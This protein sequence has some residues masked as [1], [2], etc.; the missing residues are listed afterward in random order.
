MRGL[1]ATGLLVLM[2]VAAGA[3]PPVQTAAVA[4]KQ[5]EPE[6]VTLPDGRVLGVIDG[7]S[8]AVDG[9]EWRLLG[10]DAPEI[11]TARCEGERRIG[12]IAMRRLRALIVSGHAAGLALTLVHSGRSDRHK[13][14]LGTLT[15]GGVDVRDT[16]IAELLARPYNG[17]VKKGWCSRDSRDDLVSDPPLPVREQRQ[18]RGI[19][20]PRPARATQ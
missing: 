18:Q 16:L 7:D 14:P 2:T 8:V 17:G 10:F 5:I 11:D 19:S 9:V 1:V 13:R 6:T 12:I 20:E 4:T 3:E 15:V